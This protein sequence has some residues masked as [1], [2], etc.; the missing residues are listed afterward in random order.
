[1]SMGN[2]YNRAKIYTPFDALRGL[3][4][5][6]S[7]QEYH[8]D[9]EPQRE[10]SSDRIAE[11]DQVLRDTSI[12][13]S[14]QITYYDCGQYST[15]I[16]SVIRIADDVIFLNVESVRDESADCADCIEIPFSL[17]YEL[18]ISG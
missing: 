14:V 9:Y 7:I 11:I 18:C 10:L 17:I 5:S 16:G 1:M 8:H 2:S 15:V 6:L 3:R 12:G 13:D 4:E